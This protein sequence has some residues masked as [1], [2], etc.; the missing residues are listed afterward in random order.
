[1]QGPSSS[2]L[3]RRLPL[4]ASGKAEIHYVMDKYKKKKMKA[5]ECKCCECGEQAV[6]FWPCI[7]PDIPSRPYCRKCLDKAKVSVLI[8]AFGYSEKEANFF[9]ESMK[10]INR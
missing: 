8:K 3:P 7:D 10:S 1:M 4:Q 5:S 6:A 2:A 9:V